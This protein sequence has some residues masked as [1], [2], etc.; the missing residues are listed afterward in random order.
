MENI[1]YRLIGQQSKSWLAEKLGI[2]R[3]TL[4]IR[5]NSGNWKKSEIQML[6]ILDKKVWA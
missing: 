5:L 1:A 4:D 2:S 6:L 3:P